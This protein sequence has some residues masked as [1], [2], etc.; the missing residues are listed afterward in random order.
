MLGQRTNRPSQSRPLARIRDCEQI[1]YRRRSC[2]PK[3]PIPIRRC[4]EPP[5]STYATPACE[6]GHSRHIG[7]RI[8]PTSLRLLTH[9]RSRLGIDPEVRPE[10]KMCTVRQ[11]TSP[12]PKHFESSCL[13]K[14]WKR[15]MAPWQLPCRDA[16]ID[17]YKWI[18]RPSATPAASITASLIVGCGC[19]ASM[20]S[21][22]V[23]SSLRA[24]TNSL[25]NSVTVSPIM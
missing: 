13:L 2:R 3:N 19:I 14:K 1:D 12:R 7:S 20:I 16:F 17:A 10:P 24:S 15:T 22:S 4:V 5:E 21:A 23:A 11:S 8:S 9:S 6:P 18:A 25:S